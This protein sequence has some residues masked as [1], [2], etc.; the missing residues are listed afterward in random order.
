LEKERA[1]HMTPFL[2]LSPDLPPKNTRL[3]QELMPFTG[4]VRK[5]DYF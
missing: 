3:M 4:N 5:K 1:P 2:P